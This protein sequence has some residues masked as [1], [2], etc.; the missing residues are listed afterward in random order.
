MNLE[1]EKSGI[2][3]RIKVLRNE[4]EGLHR[5]LNRYSKGQYPGEDYLD[6]GY[7]R[8]GEKILFFRG[9]RNGTVPDKQPEGG[10]DRFTGM[11]PYLRITWLVMSTA[12][13]LGMVLYD[14]KLKSRVPS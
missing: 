10:E 7:I 1:K 4:N 11:L 9:L 14:R 12:L 2:E 13:V 6:S 5:K 3:S 8:P